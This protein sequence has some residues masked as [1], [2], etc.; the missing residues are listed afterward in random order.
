MPRRG[1]PTP[2]D[3]VEENEIDFVALS[4]NTLKL[5]NSAI[6]VIT[7]LGMWA[8]WSGVLPAFRILDE[9]SLWSYNSEID[10]VVQSI[11]VTLGNLTTGLMIIVLGTIVALRLPALLEI[12]LF[13]RFNI[14]AG[15]RYAISKLTQ[16][17][18]IAAVLIMVFSVLGAQWGEIQWL[19]AALGVGIGFGCRKL[20]PILS[21]A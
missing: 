9:V 18:I 14:T 8:T 4:E 1:E 12:L 15:S 17:T 5:I 2:T 16:Y 20:S 10:G 21:A 19:V 3:A 6:I 7:A 13:A 11:P